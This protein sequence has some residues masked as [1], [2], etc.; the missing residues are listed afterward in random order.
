M[1]SSALKISTTVFCGC[2]WIAKSQG[3]QEIILNDL[4]HEG[5]GSTKCTNH[6]KG[7]ANNGTDIGSSSFTLDFTPSQSKWRPA[8]VDF[9]KFLFKAEM[10]YKDQNNPS[11]SWTIRIG[12]GGNIY[13]F[14]GPLFGEAISPQNLNN[15]PWVDEVL[16]R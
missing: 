3:I 9:E 11:R 4:F 6:K 5:T 2:F 12:R 13:S 16:Q 1:I 8:I 14:R 7:I 15:A 10:H